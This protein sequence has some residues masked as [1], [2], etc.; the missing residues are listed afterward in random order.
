[1]AFAQGG[2]A[3]GPLQARLDQL[4]ADP[5]EHPR[6]PNS[7]GRHENAGTANVQPITAITNDQLPVQDAGAASG[8]LGGV[9][10]HRPGFPRELALM[11]GVSRLRSW[12]TPLHRG[13]DAFMRQPEGRG[14]AHKGRP[15]ARAFATTWNYLSGAPRGRRLRCC[16]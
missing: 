15:V 12:R 1:M 9:V 13:L 3:R 7:I 2:R 8:A 14:E 16:P 4:A 5:C 10:V 11:A 6:C